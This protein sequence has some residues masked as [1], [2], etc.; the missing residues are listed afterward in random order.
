M[1]SSQGIG[2]APGARGA[3]SRECVGQVVGEEL[4][5]CTWRDLYVGELVAADAVASISR[6][7]NLVRVARD[8]VEDDPVLSL[9]LRDGEERALLVSRGRPGWLQQ[10]PLP[11]VPLQEVF[12]EVALLAALGSRREADLRQ[13]AKVEPPSRQQIGLHIACRS[14][15]AQVRRRIE[16][17][18]R[19]CKGRPLG[20][21]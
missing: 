20:V 8:P 21:D 7:V 6:E 5:R 10:E 14:K 11:G 1:P 12:D 3:E 17:R 9:T 2:D 19:F 18:V 15:H 13:S 16:G 4:Q